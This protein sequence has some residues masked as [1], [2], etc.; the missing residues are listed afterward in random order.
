M[1]AELGLTTSMI[2][3][4]PPNTRTAY[5][6]NAYARNAINETGS[7]A[8]RSCSEWLG[9]AGKGAWLDVYSMGGMCLCV[10][11]YVC[12]CLCVYV[13]TL[14]HPP[15]HCHEKRSCSAHTHKHTYTHPRTSHHV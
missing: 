4:E 15:R 1:C 13:C 14:A 2:R 10:C 8:R 5:R 6:G 9:S 12:V 3:I 7:L 11:V